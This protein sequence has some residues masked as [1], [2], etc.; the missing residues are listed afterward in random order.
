[1]NTHYHV[2]I[3]GGGPAGYTAA[4]YAARAGLSTLLVEQMNIGGQMALTDQIDNY[5]GYPRGIDGFSLGQAMKEGADAAGARTLLAE[6][7]SVELTG[8]I[9]T[10]HTDGGIFTSD[11]VIIATGTSHRHLGLPDEEALTGRGVHYCATCDAMFY[12]G[13]TVVVVG[14]GNTAVAAARVLSRLSKKVILVHRRDTLRA[15]KAEQAALTDKVDFRWNAEVVKL[16][17]DGRLHGILLRNILTGE[18]EELPCDGIFV[19]VGNRPNT[20]LFAEQVSLDPQGYIRAAEDTLASLRGVYAAGDVRTKNLR[21]VIT[22]AADG[23]VA[24]QAA[25]Q[26]L[27]EKG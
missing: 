9:K 17:H 3:I 10:V 5:P 16:L 12:R 7:L 23:A 22:A 11:T 4:M 8:E 19:C 13:K 2:L 21:Q 6:V 25:E 26:Y 20:E 1:M 24:A 27:A 18:E 15:G 14:G